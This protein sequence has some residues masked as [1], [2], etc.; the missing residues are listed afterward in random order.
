M[1]AQIKQSQGI[2]PQVLA[3]KGVRAAEEKLQHGDVVAWS[4]TFRYVNIEEQT[5]FVTPGGT[6]DR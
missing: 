6:V 4:H 5:I 3:A 2:E 1:P